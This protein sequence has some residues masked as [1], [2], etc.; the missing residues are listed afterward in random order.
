MDRLW[1]EWS[2]CVLEFS[3]LTDVYFSLRQSGSVKALCFFLRWF[4]ISDVLI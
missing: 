2:K 4:S 1:E 3:L